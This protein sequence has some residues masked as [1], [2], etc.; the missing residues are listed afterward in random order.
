MK[1]IK[2]ITIRNYKSLKNVKIR[3]CKTFNLFIGRPNVGKSNIIEALSCLAIPYLYPMKKSLGAIFRIERTSALFYNGNVAN[4]ID[5]TVGDYGMQIVNT[6]SNQINVTARHKE[7]QQ[8]LGVVDLKVK[9]GLTEYPI[10][11]PYVYENHNN[12]DWATQVDMPFLCPWDGNN[13]MQVLQQNEPLK[14]YFVNLLKEYDLQLT[15]DLAQQEV[16]V[17]KPVDDTSSFIIPYVALADS[18][19]R[20][21]FYKAAVDSNKDSVLMFEELEAHAYPPYISKIAQTIIQ[22]PSNQYFITT[23]SP[24]VI[25]EFLEEKSLDV[26]IHIVDYKEGKTIVKTL[27]KEEMDEVYNYGIDLFFNTEAFLD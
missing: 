25:N 12:R 15:F 8:S 23:H 24:Y 4:P 1:K 26:A 2:D 9:K 16:R 21:M 3:G 7:G 17:L 11:K 13:M 18:I 27:S 22:N 14:Q 6:A 19:K 5:I 20:L 10:F